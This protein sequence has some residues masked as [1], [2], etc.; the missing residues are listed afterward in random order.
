MLGHTALMYST[1]AKISHH[2][3]KEAK[4]RK[5]VVPLMLRQGLLGSVV[6]DAA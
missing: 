2:L 5:V 3:D 4:Q 6:G 1:H